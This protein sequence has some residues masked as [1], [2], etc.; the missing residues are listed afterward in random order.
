VRDIIAARNDLK[1]PRDCFRPVL[2]YPDWHVDPVPKG[3]PAWV[4]PP[5]AFKAWLANEP[6]RIPPNAVER[7]AACLADYVR[8]RSDA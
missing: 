1:L 7:T 2:L 4:L 8:A 6:E 3:V 5:T